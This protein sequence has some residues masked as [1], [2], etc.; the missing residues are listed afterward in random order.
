MGEQEPFFFPFKRSC[1]DVTEVVPPL[2]L[3]LL[4]KGPSPTKVTADLSF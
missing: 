1:A 3:L 2:L 4:F